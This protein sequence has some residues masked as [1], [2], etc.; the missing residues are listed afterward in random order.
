LGGAEGTWLGPN[1][2]VYED[3]NDYSLIIR[4]VY[5]EFSFLFEGDAGIIPEKEML[6]AGRPLQSTVLKV[7]HHGSSTSTSDAFL[8][9]V[10]PSY[11]VI[12]VGKN[13]DYGHPHVETLNKLNAAG[14][15]ILRTDLNGTITFK[16]EGTEL[17]IETQK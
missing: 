5:G 13:N 2:P 15:K 7:G 17:K 8:Q 9:T 16:V 3:I 4:L 10:A 6:A 14:V 11:A 12:S 1:G